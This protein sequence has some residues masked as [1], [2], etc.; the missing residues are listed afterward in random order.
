MKNLIALILLL[1]AIPCF[2]EVKYVDGYYTK[3]G[4]YR[5]GHYRDTSNDGL[6]YNNANNLGY[7]PKRSSSSDYQQMPR[8]NIYGSKIQPLG[9]SQY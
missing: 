5:S 9:R 7:N 4:K 1:I 3:S 6:S 8:P 2:A